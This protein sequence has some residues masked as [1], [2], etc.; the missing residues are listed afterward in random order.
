M[1]QFASVLFP[2]TPQ[3][4]SSAQQ[5]NLICAVSL[6]TSFSPAL[7][8]PKVHLK[9]CPVS[10]KIV[11]FL[12][13]FFSGHGDCC[14]GQRKRRKQYHLCP[15]CLSF[16][17]FAHKSKTIAC[18]RLFRVHTVVRVVVLVLAAVIVLV[19]TEN[20]LIWPTGCNCA[21]PRVLAWFFFFSA[22]CL[23]RLG[24]HRSLSLTVFPLASVLNSDHCRPLQFMLSP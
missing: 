24:K 3:L 11:H 14:R 10:R 12:L 8:R 13:F 18:Q 9:F 19:Y 21:A 15:L 5:T 1:R 2:P 7:N 16:I 6:F 22:Q 17:F 23:F 4:Q 20:R